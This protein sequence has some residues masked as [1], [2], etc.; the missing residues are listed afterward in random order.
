MGKP[1]LLMDHRGRPLQRAVM[2]QEIAEPTLTGA[3]SPLRQYPMDGLDPVILAHLLREADR[4]NPIRYFD[5]AELMEERDPHYL[6]VL[7]TRKRSVSQIEITVEEG[8][9][10]TLDQEMAE[11][12][13]DWLKRDE[14]SRELF[15]ILDAIGK[16]FSHTE[17]IWDY[18][19]RQ[20]LPGKLKW[21]NPRWF[22]FDRVTH[23]TPV[24]IGENGLEEP[25]PAFKFIF[26]DMPA[27]SGLPISSG[28]VRII[29]W[30]VLFKK[31]T[32]RD[33]AIF[34]QTYG[35]P[36]RVGKYGP[37]ANDKDR[38]TLFQAVAN[39]AGDCAAI[40]PESMMI[41]FVETPSTGAASDLYLKRAEWIDKQVSKAVLG[42]TSTTD[43]ETGGLGSGKEHREVQ[44]DIETADCRQLAAILNRDLIRPWMML[45]YGRQP[46]Y[47]RLVIARP[48]EED[49][50]AFV[51]AVGP[52]IDRGMRVG[53][54]EVRAKFGLSEPDKKELILSK[55]AAP[56]PQADPNQPD[57]DAIGPETKV[58]Y[59]FKGHLGSPG[60]EIPLQKEG[61]SAGRSEPLSPAVDMLAQ[62]ADAE[63]GTMLGQI[64]AMLAS[65][66]SLEEAYTM[67][68]EA[69]PK[70]EANGLTGIFAEAFFAAHAGGR[71]MV[72]DEDE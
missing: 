36:L 25:Y 57:P 66:G 70:I 3:R 12:V 45:E 50:K 44:Q 64:E 40:I 61:P 28:L 9:D 33:W 10:T 39:I 13:R 6:G 51:D 22:R 20:W 65:A 47:P 62:A 5:L 55:S 54:A 29:M 4:G 30:P 58:Q 31:F 67:L 35:M 2:T 32:E 41:E 26:A 1:P 38:E 42:Q 48:E 63:I 72:E 11:R 23:E 15:D 18:S 43:A 7:G 19:E 68:M 56:A 71:A 17:I 21:R 37:G 53:E 14:L 60:G 46:N 49:L 69:Y 34:T 8:G 27:K 52:M 59:L 24:M 16:G